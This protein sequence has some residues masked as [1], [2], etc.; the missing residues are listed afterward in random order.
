MPPFRD[1]LARHGLRPEEVAY[2][3]DDLGDLAVLRPA[4]LAAAVA[5]AHPAVRKSAHFV[6]RPAAAGA[7]SASSS[8]SSSRPR[9]NG[10]W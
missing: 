1:I 7:P 5:D 6:C 2:I 4:G 10:T 3:G 8:T 9:T